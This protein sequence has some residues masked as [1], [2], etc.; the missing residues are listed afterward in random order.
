MTL[1]TAAIF[2]ILFQ[3]PAGQKPDPTATRDGITA[4]YRA[5]NLESARTLAAEYA[6]AW[7]DSFLVREVEK[8]AGWPP[9]RRS[10]RLWADSL[11]RAGVEAYSQDGAEAAIAIWKRALA[12]SVAISDTAMAAAISG[13]I[14]AG[15]LRNG[16][17]DS[18]ETYLNRAA[19]LARRVG[20]VR[21]EANATTAL[22]ALREEKSDLASAR[23]HY[24]GALTLHERIGDT[25]GIAADRNNLGMLA[26]AT[27]DLVEAQR[28]F[29][30]ALVINRRDGRD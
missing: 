24:I 16:Q 12:R 2:A 15:F 9:S 22:G 17:L 19:R 23:G 27:G 11:R 10:G 14:G 5:G 1:A 25:R 29:D 8:F 20:D 7:R 30:A 3:S 13:N 18:A 6:V 26:W 28:Q 21:V 4:A